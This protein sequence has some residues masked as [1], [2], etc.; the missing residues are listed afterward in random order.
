[1]LI[2]DCSSIRQPGKQSGTIIYYILMVR[3]MLQCQVTATSNRGAVSKLP[4]VGP[5]GNNS[6][7]LASGR[8]S[9]RCKLAYRAIIK[10]KT[11]EDL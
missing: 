3:P 7:S 10:A 1:M 11:I 5:T 4:A 2:H 8:A 9:S 6:A